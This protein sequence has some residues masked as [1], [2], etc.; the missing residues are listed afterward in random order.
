MIGHL[1]PLRVGHH[2]PGLARGDGSLDMGADDEDEIR[3]VDA[4]DVVGHG[5]AAE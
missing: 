5:A 2:Q 1:D 3:V 4:R